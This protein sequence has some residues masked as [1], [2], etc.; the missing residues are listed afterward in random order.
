MT[1]NIISN[2]IFYYFNLMRFNKPIGIFLL[3]WPTYWSLWLASK[4]LPDLFILLVFTIG[5]FLMRTAGCVIN[6]IIDRN[7]DS[8]VFRTRDRPIANGD[9]TEKEAKIL[10][11]LLIFLSF[12]LVLILNKMVIFLSF[13]G[14]LLT[15]IYP[16]IK[17]FS[18]FPQV[19]LGITCGWSVPMAY[20]AVN[21]SFSVECWLLFL[22]NIIWSIIYDTEY[23]M[24]D[25]NDDIKIGIKSTAIIFSKFDKLIIC[26]LQI[27][28][29]LLLV[30]IGYYLNL[31]LPYF[32]SLIL[33]SILFIYQ[34]KLISNCQPSLYFKA[35]MNNNY[36]G[37]ILFIGI[38]LNYF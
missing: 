7:I 14:F 33:V 3:L 24:I 35:F 8:Y 31:E 15:L 11:F 17:R 22:V 4:G 6:D 20:M 30:Y 38:L 2:K 29:V 5:V 27:I 12:M 18:Y 21:Q 10:F 37:F 36:V 16:F 19:I 34:Q 9:V 28:M 26:F 25:R 1:R 23:A 13:I 32:I